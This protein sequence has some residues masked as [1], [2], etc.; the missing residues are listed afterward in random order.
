MKDLLNLRYYYRWHSS[1]NPR[2]IEKF[3]F[4]LIRFGGVRGIHL[5]GSLQNALRTAWRTLDL[6]D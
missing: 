6:K 1:C 5:F 4:A 2:G 3:T